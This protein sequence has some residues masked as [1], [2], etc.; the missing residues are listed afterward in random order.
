MF[1]FYLFPVSNLISKVS[2]SFQ[3]HLFTFTLD[4]KMSSIVFVLDNNNNPT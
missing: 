1:Y 4:F 2:K 3:F